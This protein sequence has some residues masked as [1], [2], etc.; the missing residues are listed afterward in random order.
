MKKL[1]AIVL[2]ATLVLTLVLGSGVALAGRGNNC[3]SGAHETINIIGVPHDMQ[4]GWG[5]G[6]GSR[7]FVD[8]D[9]PTTFYI[10]GGS[11]Y[12]IKDHDGTDGMVGEPG[13]GYANAGLVFPYSGGT[14]DVEIYV[15]LVGPIDSS[16]RW[17]SYFY[18]T[19]GAVWVKFADFTMNRADKKFQCKTNQ[20][21]A[22][23]YQDVYWYWD[24]KNNFKHLQMRIYLSD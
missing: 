12:E 9:S 3:P 16:F 22:A 13:R 10:Y 21:L 19:G 7:I 2:A 15:R 8:R 11:A 1:I 6:N 23:G 4:V 18:D 14:W 24:E 17:R 20:L 5:G